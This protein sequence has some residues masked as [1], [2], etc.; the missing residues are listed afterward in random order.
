MPEAASR[1]NTGSGYLSAS[2]AAILRAAAIPVAPGWALQSQ[3]G[4]SRH[5]AAR[6]ARKMARTAERKS[7]LPFRAI[8]MNPGDLRRDD[9]LAP[10]QVARH[11]GVH[12]LKH[13]GHL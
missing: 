10:R 4:S 12:P 7:R 3:N 5:T 13:R 11:P 1:R 2:F 9:R 8:A 6:L